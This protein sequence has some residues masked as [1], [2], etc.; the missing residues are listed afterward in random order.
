LGSCT[1]CSCALRS[2]N[3]RDAA[4]SSDR[5][6]HPVEGQTFCPYKGAASYYDVGDARNAA[7]SYRA[8]FEEMARIADLV[9]FEPDKVTITIDGE[10]LEPLPGQTVLPRG[11]DRNLSVDEIGG[12]QLVEPATSE[13]P[14]A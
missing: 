6:L 13:G 1:V 8:P 10:K 11:P 5:T 2:T 4:P 3:S 14:S 9:S 7:W 12:V